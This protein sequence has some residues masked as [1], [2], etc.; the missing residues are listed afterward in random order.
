M[1]NPFLIRTGYFLFSM[2]YPSKVYNRE[3][4]P[5]GRAVIVANH[6]SAV[7]PVFMF[8]FTKKGLYFLAKKEAFDKKL[9][10]KIMREAGCI[11]IDRENNDIRA[12]MNAIKVL[13]DG[14]KLIIFPEGTRNKINDELQE[15]KGGAGVFAVKTKTPIVPIMF[16]K[17]AKIFRRTRF[18]VGKPFELTE[19]YDKRLAKED[20]DSIDAVIREKMLETRA[21]LELTLSAKKVKKAKQCKS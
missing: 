5:E 14:N 6:F 21:E 9:L 19:F 4:F 2:L 17:K 11:P 18:I 13:K 1:H 7:D 3:N 10:A 16:H 15:L 12:M 8:K 20:F